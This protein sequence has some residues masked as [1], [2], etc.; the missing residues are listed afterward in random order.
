MVFAV[1]SSTVNLVFSKTKNF[2]SVERV[3]AAVLPPSIAATFTLTPSKKPTV[4]IIPT[5][6]ETPKP[7]AVPLI[8]L[9]SPEYS[10]PS[11]IM[12]PKISLYAPISVS[13]NTSEGG[14]EVPP[15]AKT[16]G[17]WRYGT[18][19]GEIGSAVL[20]G[21]YKIASGAPGVFYNLNKLAVGD[22]I[23]MTLKSGKVLTY[24][25]T[26]LNTYKVEDFPLNSFFS[27]NDARRLNLITC[28]GKY[29]KSLDNYSHRLAVYAIL[30]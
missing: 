25:V 7:T 21:H 30:K 9:S 5:P 23:I 6:T 29:I 28:A 17:W 19:P 10:Q 11:I 3:N 18:Y 1:I 4:T 14:M 26:T 2:N 20:A 16:V 22:E 27:A 8:N 13:G 24:V 12:I 15:D